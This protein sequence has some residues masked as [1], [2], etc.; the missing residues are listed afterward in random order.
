MTTQI[1]NRDWEA[2]S[3][4]L[5]GELSPR[6]EARLEVRLQSDEGLR[7]ALEDLRLTQAM[8]RSQPKLKAPRNFTLSPEMAGE[9]PVQSGIRSIFNAYPFFRL[10]SALAGILLVFVLV[11][12]FLTSRQ[13][14]S[15][16][17]VQPAAELRMA[18]ETVQLEA[19]PV[20]E[21]IQALQLP[22]AE[23]PAPEKAV[24]GEALS[25]A[26][27]K[28]QATGMP[29]T[30]PET[31]LSQAGEQEEEVPGSEQPTPAADLPPGAGGGLESAQSAPIQSTAS[32]LDWRV[33]E[34]GLAVIALFS[35]LAAWYLR[36][37]QRT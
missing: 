37:L 28:P 24:E 11:G 4:Y 36:R 31:A 17:A 32:R 27:L 21:E 12:D 34:I 1:T 16:P 22:E 29:S 23:E 14:A 30:A 26:Y 15:A 2:L 9:K 10:A 20:E 33:L 6:E 5:D 3:A 13:L 8:L 35:G 19:A 25:D 7:S 18:T